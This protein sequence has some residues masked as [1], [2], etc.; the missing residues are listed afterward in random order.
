MGRD[1]D[2]DQRQS[3]RI[4]N[5]TRGGI[6]AGNKSSEGMRPKPRRRISDLYYHGRKI[7]CIYRIKHLLFFGF[8]AGRGL[9]TALEK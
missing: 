6:N 1:V 5:Q 7:E 2:P 3:M 4:V 9:R 8:D